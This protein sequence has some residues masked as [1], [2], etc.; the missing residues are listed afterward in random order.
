MIVKIIE[1]DFIWSSGQGDLPQTIP[2]YPIV[3]ALSGALHVPPI[4]YLECI[5]DGSIEV[6]EGRVDSLQESAVQI[7]TKSGEAQIIKADN[8]ISATGY[9]LVSTCAPQK[10][11]LYY[12]LTY[13]KALPFFSFQLLR[14]MGIVDDSVMG[15]LN[16]LSHVKL[17][18]LTVP[19]GTI[20]RK[21]ADPNAPYRNIAFNGFAYS[22]LNPT[23]AFVTA[24]WICDYFD[25]RIPFPPQRTI[26]QGMCLVHKPSTKANS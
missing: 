15:D 9:T 22:L 10:S 11:N 4:G 1:D 17:H 16:N 19:P 13:F 8:I 20:H 6:I 5:R 14:D 18:R 2:N 24:N 25:N 7:T 3:Q 26:D 21:E 12:I 23:V